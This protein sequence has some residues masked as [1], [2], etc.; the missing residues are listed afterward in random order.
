MIQQ[1]G[2]FDYDANLD[3]FYDY[4]GYALQRI[5]VEDVMFTDRGYI[6]YKGYIS[7]E[8]VMDSSQGDRMEMGGM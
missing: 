4:E 7:L 8:E 6:A 1:S 2:H 5:N 3:D